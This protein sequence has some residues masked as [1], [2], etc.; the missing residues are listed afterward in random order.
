[1]GGYGA[2][3]FAFSHP[4][5]FGS[6][7]AQSPALITESPKEL[8]AQL[9]TAG[10][11]ARFM[12]GVFGNPINVAHWN[13]NSPFVLARQ[14]RAQLK[15]QAIYL[16]CGQQDEY[17][18]ADGASKIHQQLLAE[19]IRHEFHLYPGG[20]TPDYFLSHLGETLQFH[21]HVFA[22]DRAR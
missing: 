4:E 17:G 5:L 21:W 13:Q 2:L 22:D 18:F 16:N 11:L 3:R 15:A 10:P 14:N 6:V 8:N 1:M 19:G 12:G 20:H 7:S 9:R